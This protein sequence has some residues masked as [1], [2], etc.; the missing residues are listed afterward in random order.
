VTN[1]FV[2]LFKDTAVCS[3]IAVMELTKQYNTLYNNHRDHILTL[4]AITALLYMLMSYPLAVAA[5]R[6]EVRLSAGKGGR[7]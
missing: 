1:D 2:A 7:A 4:A 6:L 3:V 5:R